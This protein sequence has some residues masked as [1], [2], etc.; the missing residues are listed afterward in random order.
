MKQFALFFLF[1][2]GVL[3]VG[4][5]PSQIC[6][7]TNKA[8]CQCPNNKQGVK[9]CLDDGLH[10]S[11]CN[12]VGDEHFEEPF[13][14]ETKGDDE[15]IDASESTKDEVPIEDDPIE[16]KKERG[17]EGECSPG[18]KRA[19]YT[20]ATGTSGKGI[21]KPGEQ[22]CTTLRS[23]GAC[24]GEFTPTTEMCNGKDDDCDGQTDESFS[25]K[26]KECTLQAPKP[27]DEGLYE[28]KEGKLNCIPKVSGDVELC[29]GKD[30]NCNGQ[31]DES[32]PEK[33]TTCTRSDLEPPCRDGMYQCQGGILL[34][35]SNV[36]PTN[37]VCNGKDDDC[38]GSIDENLEKE[39]YS[40]APG[41]EGNGLCEKGKQSCQGGQWGSCV[42]EVLPKTETC[43]GKDDD[44]NGTV[45]D[46]TSVCKSGEVCKQGVCVVPCQQDSDC[47][48][49]AR[50]QGQICTKITCGG[51][52]V[53]CGHTC[54][55]TSKD[56]NH[57]GTC[58]KACKSNELCDSSVCRFVCQVDADCATNEAC[59]NARCTSLSCSGVLQNCNHQCVDTSMNAS[60]CGGCGITCS[61]QQSC[62]N[63][64]CSCSANYPT[65][66]NGQCVDTTS[67]RLHCGACNN[68]CSSGKSCVSSTCQSSWVQHASFWGPANSVAG[69][70]LQEIVVDRNS[71]VIVSGT[72]SK[73]AEL[74]SSQF[75]TGSSV[76]GYSYISKLDDKGKW[77]W[78]KFINPS[79]GGGI[80]GMTVDPQSNV[81]VLGFVCGDTIFGGS[82]VKLPTGQNCIDYIAKMDV[83]GTW[84][85]AISFSAFFRS[86]EW[87]HGSLYVTG[88]FKKNVT[89]GSISLSGHDSANVLVAKMSANGHWIWATKADGLGEEYGNEIVVNQFSE[90]FVMGQLDSYSSTFGTLTL[91]SSAT[92]RHFIGKLNKQG[93]WQ[94]VASFHGAGAMKIDD[95]GGLYF[96]GRFNKATSLGSIQLTP[97]GSRDLFVAKMDSAGKWIWANTV[98]APNVSLSFSAFTLG[99]EGIYM[100][101]Q[102]RNT[103]QF[104][105]N[106]VIPQGANLYIAKMD[107]QGQWQSVRV[108]GGKKLITCDNMRYVK[109]HLYITGGYEAPSVI[110]SVT[111]PVVKDLGVFVW[112]L[113]AP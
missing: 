61:W 28:C 58:G 32:Y 90:V 33:N 27:C 40:G 91:N 112:R 68:A 7:P 108:E 70:G 47:A 19:C 56:I 64:L 43:N 25:E 80:R 103:V 75:I 11:S 9:V 55:D 8:P 38:D 99:H 93:G 89:L 59:Q 23:W 10:F 95:L 97:K 79:S 2:F 69:A 76:H 62:G 34:C 6:T 102:I 92:N 24:L 67:N 44:C 86:L 30:D 110:D 37:E 74:G 29:N 104:G 1:L 109:E 49:D 5:A 66:C 113:P 22:T 87:A 15:G 83:H 107:F 54:V 88:S 72:F 35:I 63:S 77:L 53:A 14:P 3:S 16:E 51:T 21:C 52:L 42:G 71:H 18:M 26:G 13:K 105:T 50:C 17:P 101:G 82:T 78:A 39:C 45:D 111:L 98:G 12:C 4:C 20:G 96:A 106:T 60:H 85:W 48:T 57:C 46:P 94:W 36:K 31:V 41:T 84:Q 100:A 65:L 81:Y 73:R